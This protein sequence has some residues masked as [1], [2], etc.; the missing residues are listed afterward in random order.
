MGILHLV[1]PFHFLRTHVQQADL[2]AVEAEHGAGVSIAHHGE[3]DE[4]F[5]SAV[6][7]RAHI[8]QHYMLAARRHRGGDGRAVNARQ[9][10]QHELGGG[11]Q[12]AGIAGRDHGAGLAL[13]HRIERM[14]HAGFTPRAQSDGG[15][16]IHRNDGIGMDDLRAGGQAAAARDQRADDGFTAEKDEPRI[17]IFLQHTAC[18]MDD[19]LGRFVAAHGIQCDWER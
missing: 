11:H 18:T 16:F 2:R 3:L 14:A 15:F 6:D 8:E 5:G 1:M 17:G 13:L 9:R 10:F 4:I 12:R 19:C 7:V